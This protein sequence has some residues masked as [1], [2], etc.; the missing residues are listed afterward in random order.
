MIFAINKYE[1]K[2]CFELSDIAL[3]G[4]LRKVDDFSYHYSPDFIEE[5]IIPAL[6]IGL[7]AMHRKKVIHGD[8]KP[9]NIFYLDKDKTHP[10]NC[11]LKP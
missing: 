4:D 8:L 2:Y 9:A 10:L 11:S 7:N 6:S 3:G 5:T 1:G